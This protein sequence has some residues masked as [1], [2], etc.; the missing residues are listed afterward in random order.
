MNANRRESERLWI[1]DCG[2]ETKK[3]RLRPARFGA[4]GDDSSLWGRNAL[5]VIKN[6]SRKMR[7]TASETLA[8]PFEEVAFFCL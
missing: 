7:D 4:C 8:L 1:A 5:P 3:K 2:L 6:V